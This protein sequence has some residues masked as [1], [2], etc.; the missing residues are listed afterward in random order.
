MVE[1]KEISGEDLK[2][3]I[4][5]PIL[6]DFISNLEAVRDFVDV[7]SP[8]LAEHAKQKLMSRKKYLLPILVL[9]ELIKSGKTTEEISSALEEMYE[10]EPEM[11]KVIDFSTIGTEK[12]GAASYSVSFRM[13]DKHGKELTKTLKD[14]KIVNIQER[15]LYR[16]SLIALTC[17]AEWFISQLLH[18]YYKRYPNAVDS[19]DKYFSLNDLKKFGSITDAER[20]IVDKKVENVLRE[21]FES[22]INFF[23][24]KVN[25][26]M[27]NI[28]N[29]LPKMIEIFERRNIIVHNA[30][31]INSIYLS[32][33]D[34]KLREDLVEGME[35]S[36]DLEYLYPAIN[37]FELNLTIVLAE[38]WKKLDAKDTMRAKILNTIAQ[39]E[40]MEK[41][42]EIAQG[43]GHFVMTDKQ[44]KEREQL[45][46]KINYWE[47]LKRQGRYDDVREEIEGAD[48]SAK[49]LLFQV[50]RY[51]IIDD[52]EKFFNLIDEALRSEALKFE[53]L[54]NWTIFEEMRDN[55]KYESL[56]EKYEMQ[57]EGEGDN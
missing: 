30:G 40:L 54:E 7:I 45:R 2:K 37:A 35:I 12:M 34:P 17:I 4:F 15:H 39:D 5:P 31:K 53:K 6:F 47:S 24:D 27:S 52:S 50:M 41:R 25:L 33:V 11:E 42:W 43:I 20:Y 21:G 51:A 38:F 36:T 29:D 10:K 57:M 19:A 14:F 18:E 13:D 46:G 22:W 8:F 56:R 16:T 9:M 48:F 28:K 26:T 1:E 49:G 23:R 44:M 3:D 55:P 32:K